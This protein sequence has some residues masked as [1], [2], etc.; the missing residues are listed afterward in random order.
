MI[1]LD[2]TR[3]KLRRPFAEDEFL[4]LR[5]RFL[6]L[7]TRFLTLRTRFLTLRTRFLTPR[8]R[9]LTRAEVV[10]HARHSNL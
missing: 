2:C 3:V 8:T 6:T 9:F 10:V 7:R 1:S 4:T 5:T